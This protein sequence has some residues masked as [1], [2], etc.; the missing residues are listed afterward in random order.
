MQHRLAHA[1]IQLAAAVLP[2][3]L[4]TSALSAGAAFAAPQST[5]QT[6]AQTAST[7]PAKPYGPFAAAKSQDGLP[8]LD[9]RTAGKV[10]PI[11]AERTRAAAS[12]GDQI[13]VGWSEFGTPRSLRSRT[14]T[15][16]G[17]S[18]AAPDAIAR[19]FLA[20]HAD[21]FK[22]DA[23]GLAGFRL[24]MQDHDRSG[25][26]FLRYKQSQDGVDV[27]GSSLLVVL[28][29]EERII[30]VGGTVAPSADVPAQKL[31]AEAAVAK[32]VADVSP[33]QAKA[34]PRRLGSNRG[35]TTFANTYAVPDM[36][37][38]DPVKAELVAVPTASGNRKAWR[39]MTEVASNAEYESLVDANTGEVIYRKNQWSNEGPHGLVHTGD[40]PEA[41][42]QVANVPFSGVDGSWVAG[43]T[44]AG[45]N[46]NTFQDLFDDETPHAAD[47]PDTDAAPNQHFD[48][49][50]TDTWGLNGVL[51]TTGA[52][53]DA[54]VTQLFYY[55]NWF[56]D[57]S[58]NLG[59]TETARNFQENNFG[60][61][62]TGSD[63]VSAEADDSYG[64]GTSKLCTDSANNPVICR[65]N[66]NFNA[67]GADGTNPRMQMYVGETNGRRTQR[68]MNRDTVI[69]E[70]THGI[71]GRVISDGNLDGSDVQ[72]GA[73]GEGW[74]D[75]FAT[76]IN[77]DPVYGEYN[78]GDYDTGIRGVAYDSDNLE[79]GDLC[80]DGCQV[81][82]D[83]RIWAMAMWEE[84]AALIQ[85]YGAA[86]GKAMH[87]KLLM[88]GLKNTV[89]TP[90]FHDARTGY[91]LADQVNPGPD[92]QCLI[93]RVFADNELGMTAGPDADNDST[94]TVSTATPAT[95]RPTATIAAPATLPEGSV[96]GFNGTGST[97]AGDAGD[98]LSYAW[99]LDNDGQFDDSTS[100]TPAWTFG[101]NG[102][103]TVRLRVTNTAGYTH[104]ASRSVTVTNALPVITIDPNQLA[105]AIENNSLTVKATYTDPGW[106]D[107][108]TASVNPGSPYLPVVP[109]AVAANPTAPPAPAT[110]QVQAS[111]TYGDN[112]GY[113]LSVGVSD[114]DG[115][116]GS[117]TLQVTVSNKNP[118]ATIDESNAIMINGVPTIFA[119]AG[120]PIQ[121][122]ANVTDPGSDDLSS[123]WNWGDGNLSPL[124]KNR[125]N[126]PNDD[127]AN[128]PTV[129]P[130]NIVAAD[131]HAW[132]KSCLYDVGFN[133]VD[134]D[135]GAA[136]D[137][138]KVLIT[139]TPK[140]SQSNGYWLHQFEGI[141]LPKDFSKAELDCYLKVT[142]HLSKVFNETRDAS[143][144]DK[145]GDVLTPGLLTSTPK[146]RLD[147][148]LLTGWLNFANGGVEYNEAVVDSNNDGQVDLGFATVIANAEAVRNNP[149]ATGSQLDKQA[150][151]LSCVN[152]RDYLLPP[153]LCSLLM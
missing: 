80:D 141:L 96:V 140:K 34:A 66:A 12:L 27:H 19:D 110:G 86:T 153:L 94:P 92:N 70:Y 1:R 149:A 100:A 113:T 130:R 10:A 6:T 102:T 5:S 13:E 120:Q 98:S 32:A 114:D 99:D 127:P 134:D 93:W 143:T 117:D 48:Y 137:S 18:K 76:S 135:G 78:N 44:T 22:Q 57:Y 145:A 36:K 95:C 38:A 146:K 4:L 26:T 65:N 112:G 107:T 115:G 3:A 129:Q 101:D 150:K 104:T 63:G 52:S 69:H 148:Q 39:V 85:K 91:L 51:P 123:Q 56:H 64:D 31:S 29:A 147:T 89:D 46:T 138:A 40:D 136:A 42:G 103:F 119:D 45:N 2:I 21:L 128:S 75:A 82:N 108:F 118:L 84:R 43:E 106:L 58:Y 97:A 25:A 152:E 72:S 62:G 109:A 144:R 125:V 83:G 74:S 60:R 11:T 55:T 37:D 126:P 24:T 142:G 77:N 87:E 73:L 71:S 50:W 7:P 67:N 124:V 47:Q 90:S 17:P 121:L 41:G 14:G 49:T 132:A 59:F 33:R 122:S 139:G 68:A 9:R 23:A 15:L 54:V 8:D 133:V 20:D 79:Y 61:G 53:R 35:T 131:T 111:I 151:I 28:D 116:S 105:T 81:H 30:L 16:T 88:L